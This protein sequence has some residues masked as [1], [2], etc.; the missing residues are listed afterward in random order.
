MTEIIK[1]NNAMAFD[2][3][4]TGSPEQ[5]N[6]ENGEFFSSIFS[7]KEITNKESIKAEE[8]NSSEAK[9]LEKNIVE[10]MSLIQE[11]ELDIPN[12]I[13]DKIESSIKNF[14]QMF[15]AEDNKE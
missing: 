11:S 5:V 6:S 1:N 9:S 2:L 4:E 15:L 3:L 13:L 10:I 14:F 12:E 7:D 8:L